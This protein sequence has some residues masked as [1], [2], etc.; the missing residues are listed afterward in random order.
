MKRI[1]RT[2]LAG[3]SLVAIVGCSTS[4]AGM[5]QPENASSFTI[6]Q[7]YQLTL[8]RIVDADAECR[9][10]PLLPVG[11]VINDVQ[12]Y[13]DLR[14]AKIVQGAQGV[15]RQIYAVID[16]RENDAGSQVTLYAKSARE[17]HLKRLQR[18]ASGDTDCKL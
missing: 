6:D 10:A 17:K 11:Q 9:R 18:W 14:E 3:I 13:P 1:A 12:H 4:P 8:K 2:T 7:P 16:I 5:E 15:G